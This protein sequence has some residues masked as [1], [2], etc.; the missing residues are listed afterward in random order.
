MALIN[1][2]HGLMHAYGTV[3]PTGV[4]KFRPAVVEQLKSEQDTLTPLHQEMVW[5]LVQEF[6]TLEAQITSYQSSLKPW[7][8]GS[9][10]VSV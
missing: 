8:R 6:A 2:G 5:K 7:P 10:N 9:P 1:A 3:M 4:S